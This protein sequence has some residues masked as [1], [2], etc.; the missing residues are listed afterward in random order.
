MGNLV[1]TEIPIIKMI[2]H[3]DK[4]GKILAVGDYVVFPQRNSLELG[5]IIKLNKIMIKVLKVPVIGKSGC[6][7]NKYSRDT[8]HVQGSDATFYLLKN[9]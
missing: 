6:E 1:C 8:C 2:E 3:K 5:K 4:F 9:S 7:Y